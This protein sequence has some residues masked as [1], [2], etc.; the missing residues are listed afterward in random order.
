MAIEQYL[1]RCKICQAVQPAARPVPLPPWQYPAQCWSRVHVDFAQKDVNVFLILVDSFSK[2]I[3]VWLM[4]STSARKTLEELRVAFAT[5]GLPEL[6]VSDNRP[7]FTSVEVADFLST[8][9][10]KH[11][12]ILP[13]HAASNDG[14]ERTIQTVK[15]A[16][17]KWVLENKA[18]GK[19]PMLQESIDSFLM[20]YQNTPSSVTGESLAELF[21]ET[22]AT[23]ETFTAQTRFHKKHAKQTKEIKRT[24]RF[25][26]GAGVQVCCGR[27]CFGENC[28]R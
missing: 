20:A 10:V 6:L 28:A 17:L 27:R 19:Q 18:S 22:P 26:S 11:V 21:F 25:V 5:Y 16:L 15:K 12:R 1:Q 14:A 24:T 9:G 13:Y 3:E 8:N 4:L 2:W 23:H 7:Q